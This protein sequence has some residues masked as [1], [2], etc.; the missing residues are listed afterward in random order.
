MVFFFERIWQQYFECPSGVCFSVDFSTVYEC[1][2][3][4]VF[5]GLG[6]DAD[7]CGGAVCN[8]GSAKLTHCVFNSNFVGNNYDKGINRGGAIYNAYNLLN[9]TR[10]NF[11]ANHGRDGGALYNAYNLSMVEN[12]NF[13]SN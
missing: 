3:Q 6:V 10:S 2:L 11:I 7:F 12:S 9:V 1:F 4:S 8:Q 13:T 5:A